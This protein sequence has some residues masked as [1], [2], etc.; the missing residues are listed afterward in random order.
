MRPILAKL[1]SLDKF[2]GLIF[3]NLEVLGPVGINFANIS[4]GN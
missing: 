1:I 4:A 2:P 3:K